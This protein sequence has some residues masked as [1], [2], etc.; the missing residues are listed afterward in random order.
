MV[1]FSYLHVSIVSRPFVVVVRGSFGLCC[2]VPSCFVLLWWIQA[3]V[4]TFLPCIRLGNCFPFHTFFSCFLCF[5]LMFSLW[6]SCTHKHV[7]RREEEV[8]EHFFPPF[9]C[10]SSCSSWPFCMQLI[11]YIFC[12]YHSLYITPVRYAMLCSA[13]LCYAMLYRLTLK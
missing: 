4:F 13:L 9:F 10:Y 8:S 3:I 6:F 2:R 12:Q 7:R 5:P 1:A 11:Y